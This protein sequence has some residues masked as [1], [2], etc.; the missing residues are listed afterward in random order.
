LASLPQYEHGN[1]YLNNVVV[2]QLYVEVFLEVD[3]TLTLESRKAT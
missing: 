3:K 1:L 2:G